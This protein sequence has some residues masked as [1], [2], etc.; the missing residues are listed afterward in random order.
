LPKKLAP[1]ASDWKGFCGPI[2]QL[3]DAWLPRRLK[4]L[5]DH[6]IGKPCPRIAQLRFL[7]NGDDA[8][9]DDRRSLASHLHGAFASRHRYRA[10]RTIEP[11]RTENTRIHDVGTEVVTCPGISPPPSNVSEDPFSNN[12]VA[13][14][15][16]SQVQDLGRFVI[17]IEEVFR[18]SRRY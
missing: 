9:C 11:R 6:E 4:Y 1:L 14:E 3:A 7:R 16:V 18:R 15:T 10:V 13:K 17:T 12:V 2:G 8:G 5:H